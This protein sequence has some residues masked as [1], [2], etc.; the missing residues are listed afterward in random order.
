[1]I[2]SVSNA[3]TQNPQIIPDQPLECL[4]KALFFELLTTTIGLNHQ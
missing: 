3:E 1:M 2:E 4:P